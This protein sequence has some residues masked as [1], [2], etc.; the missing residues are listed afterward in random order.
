MGM[1]EKKQNKQSGWAKL[2]MNVKTWDGLCTMPRLP[3]TENKNKTRQKT[4]KQ[5]ITPKFKIF[6]PNISQAVFPIQSLDFCNDNSKVTI[7][8]LCSYLNYME[9]YNLNN[10]LEATSGKY[11][12]IYP[13]KEETSIAKH[14]TPIK[15]K[16]KIPA[17]PW[18]VW[19]SNQYHTDFSSNSPIIKSLRVRGFT[20][21]SQTFST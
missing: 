14:T 20:R 2:L 5:T 1:G 21:P 11:E 18:K 7:Q 8:S 4:T 13:W 3:I 12:F 15:S 17:Q 9:A 10:Y 6:F 16:A 19:T